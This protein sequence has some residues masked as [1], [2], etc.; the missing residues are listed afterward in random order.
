MIT[1]TEAQALLDVVAEGLEGRGELDLAAD[2]DSLF[3]SLAEE[4][5][6][7]DVDEGQDIE[8]DLEHEEAVE[9][10]KITTTNLEGIKDQFP[11]IRDYDPPK[12]VD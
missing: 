3:E 7:E 8:D 11:T 2:V 4:T 1:K 9:D 12:V 5:D 6:L 10:D